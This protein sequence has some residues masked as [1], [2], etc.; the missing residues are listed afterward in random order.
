M[1][2]IN[3]GYEITVSVANPTPIICLLDIHP[4]RRAD[5][6][7]ETPLRAEP[8]VPTSTYIDMFGNQCRR[9]VAVADF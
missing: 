6:R 4:E 9:L 1:M 8:L 2:L 5:I 7:A 3:Y